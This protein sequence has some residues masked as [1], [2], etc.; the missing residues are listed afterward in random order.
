MWLE[1]ECMV[2]FYSAIRV[3]CNFLLYDTNIPIVQ[4]GG[5]HQ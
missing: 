4:E 3:F 5:W 1:K 2:I